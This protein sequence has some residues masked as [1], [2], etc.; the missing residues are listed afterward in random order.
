MPEM[1]WSC[2]GGHW[3]ESENISRRLQA[4]Q[5]ELL[6]S[7]VHTE[8]TLDTCKNRNHCTDTKEQKA[9]GSQDT[10]T[11]ATVPPSCDSTLLSKLEASQRQ[12]LC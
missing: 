9:R 10:V 2:C 12:A 4:S 5:G 1:T 11:V 7:T 6:A 3:K 8:M